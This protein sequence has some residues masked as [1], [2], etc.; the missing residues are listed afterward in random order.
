MDKKTADKILNKIHTGIKTI[1]ADCDLVVEAAIEDMEIKNRP[2]R[3][4]AA[5]CKPSVSSQQIRLP[6]PL[7]QS[8]QE[9]TDR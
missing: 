5:I 4:L 3:E 9:L 1:C 2:S 8:A 7:R 6:C